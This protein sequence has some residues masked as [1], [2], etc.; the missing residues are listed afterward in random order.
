MSRQANIVQ[1]TSM[2]YTD[3]DNGDD[4]LPSP[5]PPTLATEITRPT[6]S[7]DDVRELVCAAA[8]TVT[9]SPVVAE[10]AAVLSHAERICLV[11]L[12]R[13]KFLPRML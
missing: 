8:E 6:M 1:T 2:Y 7:F 9:V 3:W 13:Q 4:G 10:S 5:M 11:C 12:L